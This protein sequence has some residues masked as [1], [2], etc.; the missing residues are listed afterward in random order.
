M[1]ICRDDIRPPEWTT[2]LV[3]KVGSSGIRDGMV[4][5]YRTTVLVKVG[6]DDVNE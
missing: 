5:L 3:L 1:K 2:L 6:T 4:L